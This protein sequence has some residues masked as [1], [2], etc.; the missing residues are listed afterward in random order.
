VTVDLW[1]RVQQLF[2]AALQHSPEKRQEFLE[3]ECGSNQELRREVESLLAAHD[4]SRSFMAEPAVAGMAEMPQ[5]AT[6]RFQPGDLLGA[7]KVLD[8]IGRG[9]MGEVYRARDARLKRDV[10]IK[11]LPQAFAADRERLRRF[12]QEARS[13]AA[14]NHPNIISVHDMGTADGSP[15]IVSEMLEGQNL[16]EVVRH[17]AVAA[18]KALDYAIQTAH[19]LAAAHD[20][21]IVHRDLKPENLF[22]TKDGR[23]KILDFGLAK[24]T[25]SE[26][27]GSDSRTA[28]S[29]P[30]TEAGRVF[31]TVGYMSPEQVRGQSA[32]HRSDIFSFGAILYELF[33]GKRAFSGDSPADTMSAI[34]HQDPPELT[35]AT[36]PIHPAVGHTIRHCLEKNPLERY[37]SAR[38]LAFQLQIAAEGLFPKVETTVAEP[39]SFRRRWVLPLAVALVLTVA[40]PPFLVFR[41]SAKREL[42][43]FKRLTFRSGTI[44]TA[45]FSGDGRTIIYGAAWEG[46]PSEIFVSRV[47]SSE[48]RP[49]GIGP[50]EL[51]S[52]SKNGELAVL[53][54]P[55]SSFFMYTIGTLATVPLEGGTPRE[56]AEDVTSAD[57]TPD[58]TALA[59]V[60]AR[61]RLEFPIGNV[62]FQSAG[63][64]S[65]LRFSPDGKSIAFIDHPTFGALIGSFV[66]CDLKGNATVIAKG[67]EWAGGVAWFPNGKEVWVSGT[68]SGEA[69]Q[70]IFAISR[71]GKMRLVT[72][73]AGSLTLQDI[74]HGGRML[75]S[76][77]DLRQGIKALAPDNEERDLSWF[78]VS[79]MG[80]ISADG[81][82]IA[83]S[84]SGEATAL[85]V[86]TYV[87]G[88]RGTPPVRLGEGRPWSISPDKKWVAVTTYHFPPQLIL[89]PTSSGEPKRY[90]PIEG[91]I[92][93][94]TF[95]G[96]GKQ[97]IFIRSKGGSDRMYLMALNTG[98]VKP[99]L[100]EG[101]IGIVVSPDGKYL[102][103]SGPSD[104]VDKIYDL[105]GGP[106]RPIKGLRE[107]EVVRAWG[108]PPLPLYVDNREGSTRSLFRLDPVTGR[109]RFWRAWIRSR[110]A[111]VWMNEDLR[112][113]TDASAYGYSYYSTLSALYIVEGVR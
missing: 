78:D 83:F 9:G 23:L 32:D 93:Y 7:Y 20:V 87:R 110:A 52:V 96:D 81:E 34:L 19:G 54:K 1:Q 91:E 74:G 17:G 16:R 104:T 84:E 28:E 27:S 98:A 56:I 89:L 102:V 58:G 13:A 90:P 43:T 47:D 94:A 112:I 10:A 39:S 42:P 105:D 25:R 67:F 55:R 76:R 103:A 31:G 53:L 24:L 85:K 29:L 69:A 99:I 75:L 49:L 30:G 59:I 86:Y 57:W 48:A 107:H 79:L 44:S 46:N 21:G 82:L 64:L 3:Q 108:H 40:L 101:V 8:L 95:L 2:D 45:R 12:E 15:Y 88:I 11:V 5:R 33:S 60:R 80:A 22:I 38:D 14:L 37:Q 106:P 65:H 62:L 61:T 26:G 51:L 35:R 109:R 4:Q 113:A 71:D 70:Q 100:P 66:T 6:S 18:R 92:S 50:S 77:D 68:T 63:W 111:G 97:I 41:L 73:G 72:R 36:P